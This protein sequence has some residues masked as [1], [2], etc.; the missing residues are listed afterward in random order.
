MNVNAN[1]TATLHHLHRLADVG[2]APLTENVDFNETNFFS[3]IHVVLRCR[4]T[5]GRQVE[6]G[7]IG[8]WLFRNQHAAGMDGALA[9]EVADALGDGE[10]VAPDFAL[11][12]KGRRIALHLVDFAFG[13]TEHLAQLT[14]KRIVLKSDRRAEQSHMVRAVFVENVLD[15]LFAVA[16]REIEV[17]IWWAATHGVEETLEIQVQ[18]NRIHIG[19]FQAISHYAIGPAAPPDMIEALPDGKAHDV[20][21]DE[22]IGAKAHPLDDVQLLLDTA[23][24]VFVVQAVAVRH[25]V[26]SQFAQ[27]FAVV[28]DIARVGALVFH[29]VVQ[30]DFTFVQD[31]LRIFNELRIER[32]GRFQ[33][34]GRQKYLIGSGTSGRLKA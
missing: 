24:S 29:A 19:D 10:D 9:W 25:A 33:P 31:T 4:E 1:A 5:F 34:F 15:D 21:S 27:Q 7:E 8:N 32:K 3:G 28:I 18:F 30:V 22:E 20:P 6:G 17:E 23:I 26:E 2:D 12:C 13:Q 16:P 14:T 11:L